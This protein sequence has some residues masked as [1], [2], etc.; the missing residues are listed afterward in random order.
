VGILDGCM[1]VCDDWSLDR[2]MDESFEALRGEK[3]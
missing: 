3:K 2:M 1:V